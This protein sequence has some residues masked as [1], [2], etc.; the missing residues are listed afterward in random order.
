MIKYIDDINLENKRVLIRVDFNVPLTQ[1]GTVADDSRI[2]A[3]LPTIR[4]AMEH[5]A[6]VILASHMGR[7]NGKPNPKYSLAPVAEKLA[8]IFPDYDI[9]FPEDC[10]G[11]GIRK[12]TLDMRPNQL[13]LLEN[14]RFHPGE[15][16][17]DERFGKKLASLCDVYINDAFGASHRA[18]ASVVGTP[19][20]I[21]ERGAG[22]LMKH[23][24]EF[25]GKLTGSPARPFVAILGGSKVSDKIDVIE[26]LLNEVDQLLIGGAMSYTFL[27]AQGKKLGNSLVETEKIHAAKKA[28]TRAQNKGIPILLPVDHIIAKELD[29]N[30][31][32]KITTSD[33]IPPGWMG[34][35]IGP[36][37]VEI[38]IQALQKA[39][40][41]FW[42]GPVGVYEHTVFA[43]G[44][45]EIAKALAACK[46]IT[47][48]GGGDSAAAVYDAHVA[49]KISHVSTGGG[50]SLEFV[51]GLELPGLKAL[52]M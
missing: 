38:F 30:A 31:P 19:S 12:L 11:D 33:E 25:L 42:N 50:A 51:K 32:T 45:L 40:T 39:K 13:I 20:F 48:V 43:Q 16:I 49:D 1:K 24:I 3:C 21:T 36:K 27:A 6:H 47:V 15:E 46:A 10:V 34:L 41:I 22:F 35:D 4:Y 23:E 14:L 37:T 2:R 9:I 28:L 8:D 26:S 5:K 17:N 29:P 52:E 18:H 7:P 44:T